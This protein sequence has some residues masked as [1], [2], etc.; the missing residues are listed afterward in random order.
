MKRYLLFFVIIFFTLFSAMGQGSNTQSENE[1]SVE[2]VDLG[3]S[4]RWA[5][6]NVGASK[7]EEVGSKFAWG[8]T[9]EKEQFDERG[10]KHYDAEADSLIK[11]GADGKRELD[12]EDD[13]ATVNMG[14][15]WRMPTQKEMQELTE[16]CQW[17]WTIRNGVCGCDVIGPNGNSIFMPAIVKVPLCEPCSAP[18]KRIGVFSVAEYKRVSFSQGNLQC[19]P[20]LRMWKFVESQYDF[21][22]RYKCARWWFRTVYRFVWL[23][24]RQQDSSIWN[25]YL[26]KRS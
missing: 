20:E 26:D 6:C 2:Y 14:E 21:F 11:Y 7:P 16:K 15:D 13:A 8:E 1:D 24:R 23:E 4:V 22:R 5:T 17:V 3:L 25:Y 10:Y 18:P 19:L 9:E 12:A